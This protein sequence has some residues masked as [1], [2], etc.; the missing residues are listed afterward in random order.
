MIS[1]TEF[2]NSMERIIECRDNIEKWLDEVEAAIGASDYM[3]EKVYSGLNVAIDNLLD[4]FEGDESKQEDILWL[5][6][7]GG[8]EMG[9][10]DPHDLE[11][12][13]YFEINSPTDLWDMWNYFVD[14]V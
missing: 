7:E 14:F 9:I 3:F 4:R 13:R 10:T 2:I 5:I 6:N 12:E 11:E 8:G 1:K